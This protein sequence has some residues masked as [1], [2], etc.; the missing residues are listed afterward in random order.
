MKA[1]PKPITELDEAIRTAMCSELFLRLK[2]LFPVQV[3]TTGLKTAITPVMGARWKV[4]LNAST[5]IVTVGFVSKREGHV[6]TISSRDIPFADPGVFDKVEELIT[7][8]LDLEYPM[9]SG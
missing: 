2:K 1:E 5:G 8:S 6:Y 3:H 9:A 7:L 4:N